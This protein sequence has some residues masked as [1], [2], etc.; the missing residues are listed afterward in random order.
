MREWLGVCVAVT[1]VVALVSASPA[2]ARNGGVAR[3]DLVLRQVVE[4]MPKDE[5]QE[6]RVLTATIK[7]GDKT[8]FH[9]HR[10]PVTVYIM[11]GAF[12]LEM[13]GRPPVTVKAGESMVEP[14]NVRMTGYNRS[15]S[16]PIRL[17]IFYVSDP[18]TP[19]LDP[20]R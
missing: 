8:V 4:G 13:E 16:E 3:P 19:F 18:D 5:R 17:V 14:P 6:I 7:P 9:T 11:E 12:T 10:S 1:A 20:V 2:P 15:A